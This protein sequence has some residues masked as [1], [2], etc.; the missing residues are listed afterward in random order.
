MKLITLM[1]SVVVIMMLPSCDGD[2]NSMSHTNWENLNKEITNETDTERAEVRSFIGKNVIFIGNSLTT[3]ITSILGTRETTITDSSFEIIENFLPDGTSLS[4]GSATITSIDSTIVDNIEF[5][6]QFI[7]IVDSPK[8]YDFNLNDNSEAA[9]LIS[10]DE[11]SDKY[12]SILTYISD[13]SGTYEKTSD[14]TINGVRVLTNETGIFEI[15][16]SYSPDLLHNNIL[17]N[18]NSS[19]DTLF[20]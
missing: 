9:I 7:E 8:T 11:N 12:I 4:N 14:Q 10:F 15:L 20:D 2:D 6:G 3:S 17:L 13:T 5:G 19:L 18:T 16:D 1:S